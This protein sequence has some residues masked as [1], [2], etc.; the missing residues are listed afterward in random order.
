MSKGFQ[1]PEHLQV[2]ALSLAL[3]WERKKVGMQVV[4]DCSAFVRSLCTILNVN[5]KGGKKNKII[6]SFVNKNKNIRLA[7]K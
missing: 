5:G 2:E 7:K 1:T 6:G 4:A 3:F